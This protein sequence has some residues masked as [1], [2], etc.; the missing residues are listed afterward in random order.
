MQW[1]TNERLQTQPPLLID[2][3]GSSGVCNFAT[4]SAHSFRNTKLITSSGTSYRLPP[5]F[6]H[7]PI[8]A[9]L[10]V[11]WI[12]NRIDKWASR[13]SLAD[14]P[15]ELI[16]CFLYDALPWAFS[17]NFYTNSLE[18]VKLEVN[19]YINNECHSLNQYHSDKWNQI[20]SG[21]NH[22]LP[23]IT[24]RSRLVFGFN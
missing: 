4:M 12:S 9:S 8:S 3:T 7:S 10:S 23:R 17:A 1:R 21:R 16:N 22:Y 5:S 18:V 24:E 19:C 20:V 6:E 14:I 15:F 13:S 2:G 11:G